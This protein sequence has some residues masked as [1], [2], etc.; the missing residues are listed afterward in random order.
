MRADLRLLA[1]AALSAEAVET[2]LAAVDALARALADG[3]EADAAA[4]FTQI[5]RPGS[6]G[7]PP[8]VEPKDLPRRGLGSV[9]G[10]AA[11][12]HA[13]AHIEFNAINLA[14]DA[15]QRFAGMPPA[16]Y[17]DWAG[18]A[19]DE[20]RHFRLL[21]ARMAELGCDY[22]D[23][24]AHDGL[25]AMAERTR[26]DCLSRMALVPRLLEA[27]GLDVTPGMIARLRQVGDE[28]S[29]AM[30][31]VILREEVAHVAIGTRWFRH[32]CGQ[33]GRDPEPTFLA[34]LASVGGAALSGPFN[35]EA[36]TRAGFSASEMQGISRLAQR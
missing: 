23:H 7:K 11:L 21:R 26:H 34:L 22:G 29:V 17:R 3:T 25:W 13:I 30:L 8:L 36:R 20:A 24:P 14:C 19:V 12:L 9:E 4:A 6:P 31:E 1:R 27:R 28:A 5:G 16:F 32:C 33:A 15:V 18:V 10:R 2:K 35:L